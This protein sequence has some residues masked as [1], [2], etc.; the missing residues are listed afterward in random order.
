L[1]VHKYRLCSVPGADPD[2]MPGGVKRWGAVVAD[3]EGALRVEVLGPLRAFRGD[4]ELALG[5]PRQRAV[6]AALLLRAGQAVRVMSS[7]TRCGALS[8]RR[9]R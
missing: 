2:R 9:P 1:I 8:R 3:R 6:L 5:W 7:S 4:V